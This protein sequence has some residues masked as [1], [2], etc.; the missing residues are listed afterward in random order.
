AHL[1]AMRCAAAL[2]SPPE[3]R[4]RDGPNAAA[5]FVQSWPALARTL[6]RRLQSCPLPRIVIR[7][8][9]RRL[10]RHRAATEASSIQRRAGIRLLPLRSNEWDIRGSGACPRRGVACAGSLRAALLDR[11][12][13][14]IGGLGTAKA[15][16]EAARMSPA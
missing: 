5:E 16:A 8:R 9:R 6:L 12:R 7:A 2:R 3:A 1:P 15:A 11:R 10:L 4:R 14:S 13:T